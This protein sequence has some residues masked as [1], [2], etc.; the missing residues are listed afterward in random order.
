MDKDD[1]IFKILDL[2]VKIRIDE[3]RYEE[4]VRVKNEF[5][6]EFYKSVII[7]KNR[8]LDMLVKNLIQLDAL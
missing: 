4:A 6:I 2:K 7:F 5:D 1:L 8:D 3:L